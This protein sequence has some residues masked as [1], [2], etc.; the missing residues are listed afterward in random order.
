VELTLAKPESYRPDPN[1][2]L[3]IF[4]GFVPKALPNAPT[5]IAAPPAGSSLLK[6]TGVQRDLRPDVAPDPRF[7][8]IDF[9]AI[10]ITR[11]EVV[12]PPTWAGVLLAAGDTPLVLHG[13]FQGQPRTIWTFDPAESNLQGRLAF[14]L[15]TAATLDTLLPPTSDDLE[16]GQ[17]AP[18]PMISRAGARISTGTML[19]SPGIYRW[20][21][22]DG[23]AA[24]N[25][26]DGDESDL[27]PRQRPAISTIEAQSGTV[28]REAGQELWRS[29]LAAAIGLVMIEWL[30]AHRHDLPGRRRSRPAGVR[31]PA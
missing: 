9:T 30:Y 17:Q 31:R 2:D 8:R 3:I 20:A 21:E 11:A 16:V 19:T 29:L 4:A 22:Q 13:I 15:L 18:G 28:E 27:R 7:S 14:P 23:S 24:V 5:L 26:L 6:M 10:R 1:A 12:E 25:A